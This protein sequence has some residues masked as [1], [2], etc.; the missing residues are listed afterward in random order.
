MG[1]CFGVESI[2]ARKSCLGECEAAAA[3]ATI[4]KQRAMHSAELNFSAFTPC[5]IPGTGM[6]PPVL[7]WAFHTN[8]ETLPDRHTER[9]FP[10]DSQVLPS[11]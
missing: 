9:L 8:L 6:A 3:A 2:I 1:W 5:G 4:R 11:G 7:V 10:A